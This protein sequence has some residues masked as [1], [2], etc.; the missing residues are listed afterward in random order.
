MDLIC[1]IDLDTILPCLF[2]SRIKKVQRV[3]DAHELF[4]ELKEVI[5]RGSV[6]KIWLRIER[7]AV[8]KFT[9]GY[10]VSEGIASE[11]KRR[12]GVEY[13]TIRNVPA[14]RSVVPIEQRDDFIL[15]QGAVNEGRGLEWLIPAM[16]LINSKLVVCGDGNFMEKLKALIGE[17]GV[18]EN[19]ELKGLVSP[20]DLYQIST[21]AKIGIALAEREGL[22]QY[23]ALPNKF[24][25]YIHARLPQVTMNY[26][27]YRQINDRFN[28]AILID[29]L[30]PETIAMA[31]NGLLDNDD[32]RQQLSAN[33]KF[34]IEELNWDREKYK[35]LNFYER[36]LPVKDR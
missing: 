27:E 31:V 7:Y 10:T 11:F 1:A 22:N 35:L 25:D 2:V 12:Y 29:D 36:I 5:T 26:P 28:I 32:L 23:L 13:E 17:N 19:V 33:C 15:Y 16:K 24:F 30:K 21:R 9:K 20:H 34:A 8:P 4:S 14:L 6:Q 3:Y 18:E